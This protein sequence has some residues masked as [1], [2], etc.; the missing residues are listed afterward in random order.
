MDERMLNLR[1]HSFKDE[2]WASAI[3]RH[4]YDIYFMNKIVIDFEY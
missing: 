4:F 3:L 1:N 2:R